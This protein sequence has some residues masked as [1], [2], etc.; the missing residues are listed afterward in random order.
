MINRVVIAFLISVLSVSASAASFFENTEQCKNAA[1][2]GRATPYTPTTK[3][4]FKGG[5]GWIKKVVPAGGACLGEAHVL[6]D[7]A[8]SNGK[9]V[10]VK[11]GFVYWEQQ[12]TGAFRMH[13]CSNPFGSIVL[14][15]GQAPAQ[16]AAAQPKPVATATVSNSY[17]TEIKLG[18]MLC[19]VDVMGGQY[20]NGQ[21]VGMAFR[22]DK[23]GC[24]EYE[25]E[26]RQRFVRSVND[27]VVTSQASSAGG[28]SSV[29]AAAVAVVQP[30][31]QAAGNWCARG[32]KVYNC[33]DLLAVIRA[34]GAVACRP[35]TAPA[36]PGEKLC[37]GVQ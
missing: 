16:P 13:D 1:I 7:G 8:P 28:T 19:V 10:F 23:A 31:V 29:A 34:D 12:S 35:Q 33:K 22:K 18:E 37:T 3:A 25:L 4:E 30:A 20:T 14:V 5:A 21:P 11:E 2:A 6:E 36:E 9:T 32:G 17:Y 15:K 26:V 27:G 24:D